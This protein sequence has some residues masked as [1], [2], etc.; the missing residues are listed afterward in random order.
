M[1]QTPRIVWFKR[2]LRINDHAPLLAASRANAPIIPLYIVEPEYWHQPFASRRHWH[3][4]QD[5]LCD[6]DSGLAE[7]GQHLVVKVGD[8]CEVIKKLHLDHDVSHVYAH[9]ETGNLWTYHRDIAVQKLRRNH[10]IALHEAPTNGV[11]RRLRSRVDWFKIRNARMAEKI[12]PKPNTLNSFPPCSSDMDPICRSQYRPTALRKCRTKGLT[13]DRT[14]S[15]A[16]TG[17]KNSCITDGNHRKYYVLCTMY[18]VLCTMYYVL[19]TMYYV[20]RAASGRRC[21]QDGRSLS[22]CGKPSAK[23]HMGVIYF[24]H[25]DASGSQ[26][27]GGAK[28]LR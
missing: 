4:I 13:E 3:F 1:T 21:Y 9:E 14:Q 22:P 15:R 19:C 17:Q 23:L 28:R 16:L 18:Y 20:L 8:S 26:C 25:A 5:C 27:W 24:L 7:L 2:D 10:G 12:L 11:V 6:L